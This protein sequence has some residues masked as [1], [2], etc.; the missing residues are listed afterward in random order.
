MSDLNGN[1]P[2]TLTRIRR[3]VQHFLADF[4][5]D[6]EHQAVSSQSSLSISNKMLYGLEVMVFVRD[7]L[8]IAPELRHK[9]ETDY[10]SLMDKEGIL[11]GAEQLFES[12]QLVSLSA[13]TRAVSGA[14]LCV[15]NGEI[16]FIGKPR[17]YLGSIEVLDLLIFPVLTVA[18]VQLGGSQTLISG[19][20]DQARDTL[21]KLIQD[22]GSHVHDAEQFPPQARSNGKRS[23]EEYLGYKEHPDVIHHLHDLWKDSQKVKQGCIIFLNGFP[24]VGKLTIARAIKDNLPADATC[25][26][27]NHILID[28]AE[29]IIPGRGPAHKKLRQNIRRVAFEALTEEMVSQPNLKVIMTGCIVDSPED[30]AVLAEHL[31]VAKDANV[32]FYLIDVT[33]DREEHGR[34]LETIERAAEGKSKLRDCHVLQQLLEQYKRIENLPEELLTVVDIEHMML[35]TTGSTVDQTVS[36]KMQN[37]HRNN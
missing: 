20:R 3:K 21:V 26:I 6:V 5:G 10:R 35:D 23:G 31:R 15:V 28:P 24:G 37:M 11:I 4:F 7:E 16:E 18:N 32:P 30:I 2:D 14:G 1:P 33:C 17:K 8:S 22:V 9:F 13:A 27:D 36:K 25:L 19:L 34:R 12:K 29:A